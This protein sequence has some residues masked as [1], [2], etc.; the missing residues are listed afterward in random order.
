MNKKLTP[1]QEQKQN[2]TGYLLIGFISIIVIG[3][4]DNNIIEIIM[5][6]FSTVVGYGTGFKN[7]KIE[8]EK[9]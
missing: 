2:I 3:L 7:G 1:E 4:T 5:C 6:L 8:N 9:E